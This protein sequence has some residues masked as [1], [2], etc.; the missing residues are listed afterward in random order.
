MSNSA[1]NAT[2]ALGDIQLCVCQMSV[3]YNQGQ[4]LK[5]VTKTLSQHLH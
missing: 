2:E 5:Y 4:L 3:E 1:V